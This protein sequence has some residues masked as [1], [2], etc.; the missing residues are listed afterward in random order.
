[1]VER[2]GD[3]G[4]LSYEALFKLEIAKG[5]GIY[6]PQIEKQLQERRNVRGV[7]EMEI[8]EFYSVLENLEYVSIF[9]Y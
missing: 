5:K 7:S 1:M 3:A 2:I 8:H 6:I 4:T 9:Q